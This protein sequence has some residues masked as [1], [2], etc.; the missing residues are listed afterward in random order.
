[1]LRLGGEVCLGKALLCLGGEVFLGEALLRLGGL[2]SL[3]TQALGLPRRG[4]LR[5]GERSYA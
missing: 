1:M 3:E 5:P 2:E 4:F